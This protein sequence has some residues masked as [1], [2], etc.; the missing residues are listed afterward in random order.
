ME[1]KFRIRSRLVEHGAL[2]IVLNG[3]EIQNL[4]I[5]D[6][7]QNLLIVLNGIEIVERAYVY[8]LYET[9]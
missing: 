7:R 2:L 6:S 1:L 8:R 9:F 5:G 3:I 4:Y